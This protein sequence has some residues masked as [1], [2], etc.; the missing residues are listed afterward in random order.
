MSALDLILL[1][2][3]AY[4]AV[5]TLVRMMRRRREGIIED[6]TKEVELEQQRLKEE[7]KKEKRRKMREQ[8]EQQQRQRR[9]AA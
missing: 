8:I 4:L 1:G 9:G 3:A 6:L 2:I 7:R 5:I